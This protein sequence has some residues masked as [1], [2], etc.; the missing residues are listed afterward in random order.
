M[1]TYV[2][3]RELLPGLDGSAGEGALP[4]AVEEEAAPGL[5][6]GCVDYNKGTG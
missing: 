6:A 4:H 2:C 3:A 5:L 1:W